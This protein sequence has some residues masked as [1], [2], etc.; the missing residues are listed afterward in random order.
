MQSNLYSD[1]D[2]VFLSVGSSFSNPLFYFP[3]C[4]TEIRILTENVDVGIKNNK[5][6][7]GHL[8]VSD[9]EDVWSYKNTDLNIFNNFIF[10]SQK[11]EM[12]MLFNK[13]TI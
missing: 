11:L 8:F 1:P 10:N 3:T 9:N 7:P 2:S 13:C 6:M 4:R 12:Q 5:I